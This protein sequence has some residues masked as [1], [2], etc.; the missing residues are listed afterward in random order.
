MFDTYQPS[1][2]FGVMLLPLVLLGV[3]LA[4]AAAYVYHLLLE[5]IPL[6]YINFLATLFFGIGIGMV[7]AW[8]V[9]TSHTRSRMIAIGMG[10]LLALSALAGKYYFQHQ[11][12]CNQVFETEKPE[13]MRELDGGLAD[14]GQLSHEER[15]R[16]LDEIRREFH[17][18]FSILDHLKLRADQGWNIGRGGGAPVAGVF[19]YLVW[20]VEAGML[21]FYSVKGSAAAAGE[22][23]SEKLNTWAS[24][25]E[26]V[27]SLP[28]TSNEMVTQIQAATSVDD[29][30]SLPVPKTDESD[31]FA[32]YRVNSIEGQELE[33]AYLS[34]DQLVL[35]VN[36]KGEQETEVTSLVRH[37]VLSSEQRKQLLENADLMQEAFA[38]Y[39]ESLEAEAAAEAASAPSGE[40]EV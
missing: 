19:V 12:F 34:V 29:L 16:V 40:G 13:I 3:V 35:S 28:I 10:I 18:D 27:M 2:K 37:A 38:A 26:T 9:R 24:E 36:S 21:L 22:P 23:Y 14:G 33:D 39:R 32:I 31:K 30:L 11:T 8:I 15:E 5:H 25:E 17:R 20:L 6:I 7:G 1:G 4:V